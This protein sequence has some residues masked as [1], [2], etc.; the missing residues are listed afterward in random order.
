VRAEKPTV[1]FVG[2]GMSESFDGP[3]GLP[4]FVQG[5]GKLLDDLAPL[6]ARVALLS[7][8]F[9]EDLG[10]PFPDPAEHNRQ[11]EAYTAAMQKLAQQRGLTFIDLYHPLVKDKEER[12]RDR[13]TSNGI[14]LSALGYARVAAA[15]ERQL[16]LAPASWQVELDATGK[17][18]AARAAR[19]T[20]LTATPAQVRFRLEDAMLPVDAESAP[21]LR[22]SGLAAGAY[23]LK[24]DGQELLTA[25]SGEWDKGVRLTHPALFQEAEVLRRAIVARNEQFYRRSR[26]FND[27]ERHF[28]FLRGDYKLYDEQI[29]AQEKVIDQCRQAKAHEI[30]IVR[31]EGQR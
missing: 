17:V 26:P 4:G 31:K 1:L 14:L 21:L 27:H 8:T 29:A 15:V 13:L 3:G 25:S 10:R 24:L 28:G 2:Y 6:Q 23:A 9:H 18:R 16:G 5:L 7:P 12:S 22:V 19:V 20:G 11:L 30:E